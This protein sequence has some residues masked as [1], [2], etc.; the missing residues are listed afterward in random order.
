MLDDAQA[1][2]VTDATD[3]ETLAKVIFDGATKAKADATTHKAEEE[4]LRDTALTALNLAMTNWNGRALATASNNAVVDA[5]R[6]GTTAANDG[7]VAGT[8]AQLLLAAKTALNTAVGKC[9][10]GAVGGVTGTAW[11]Q[12]ACVDTTST[13]GASSATTLV[14]F[15]LRK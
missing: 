14:K 10:P 1:K 9:T 5:G 3:A 12:A 15:A 8:P 7:F 6:K 4:G 2:R 11:T 13:S